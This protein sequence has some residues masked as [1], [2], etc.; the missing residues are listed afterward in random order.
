[1]SRRSFHS[2]LFVVVSVLGLSNVN[3]CL[4]AG[5]AYRDGSTIRVTVEWSQEANPE[6]GT[7]FVVT[8]AD[9]SNPTIELKKGD[10]QW[11]VGH[12]GQSPII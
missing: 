4:A 6:H 11:R 7:D 3:W 12:S 8:F 10:L 5:S 9:Q 1:M 2:A